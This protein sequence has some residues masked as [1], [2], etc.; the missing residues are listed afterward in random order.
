MKI[1]TWNVNSLRVRLPH[2]LDWLAAE[3]PDAVC[4]QETKCEDA[5]FPAEALAAA[6]YCSLHHGQR[7]YNG[8][9][10]LT[11]GECADPCRGIPGFD[12]AQSRVIAAHYRG[13][14]LVC[15]YVPNGQSVGSEK[16]AYKLR[17]LEALAA[18]LEGELAAHPRLAV[19][20]D[21][22]IAPEARDVHDP[23]AWEGQVLF[24][25]PERAALRRLLDL[26][27]ADA[28]RLFEQ[29]ENAFTWWDYRMAAFRRGMGLRIDHVLLSPPLAASARA[30]AIDVA[31]RRLDRPSD[32]APVVCTLELPA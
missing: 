10:I 15:V 3:A 20:G 24:S 26:G 1:A 32:H 27:L 30:C 23:A 14:R 6:G 29:P 8:V 31:P 12:D 4:L 2:L 25:E 5:G 11:R 7:T 28:F 13:V 16:Y 9:A 19:L 21:F 17:W 18:W 22:N